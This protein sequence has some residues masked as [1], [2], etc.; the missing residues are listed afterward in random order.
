[1]GNKW[2]TVAVREEQI[3]LLRALHLHDDAKEN[4]P[5]R[6][7]QA[8]LKRYLKRKL[9]DMDVASLLKKLSKEEGQT[10]DHLNFSDY[11]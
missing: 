2:T 6:V 1:M 4:K 5:T 8:N 7:V 11:Q 9:K 10:F 3:V